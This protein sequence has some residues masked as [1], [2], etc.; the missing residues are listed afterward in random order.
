MDFKLSMP[1]EATIESEHFDTCTHR[2]DSVLL[3]K[4]AEQVALF[5]AASTR[6]VHVSI[7]LEGWF[8][9]SP[10][11][12]TQWI[13]L[14]PQQEIEFIQGKLNFLKTLL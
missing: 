1:I 8:S 10:I 2:Q 14:S 3:F 4:E 5:W 6:M 9:C 11:P 7:Q 12:E 13:A